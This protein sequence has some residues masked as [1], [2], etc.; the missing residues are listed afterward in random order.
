MFHYYFYAISNI[1]IAGVSEMVD[2]PNYA[3]LNTKMI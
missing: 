1:P 3:A 2:P